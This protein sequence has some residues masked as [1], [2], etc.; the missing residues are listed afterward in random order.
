M[1]QSENKEVLVPGTKTQSGLVLV[2]LTSGDLPDLSTADVFPFDLAADY[3]TP[4][5]KGES[6]R[7][8]FDK[9]APQKVLDQ[10]T[11]EVIELECA[12]F[13]EVVNGEAK[14]ISNGSKRLVG[15]LEANNIQRGAP[16]LITYL[17]K[18]KN[19]SNGFQSDSW[20]IKMLRLSI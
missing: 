9:I 3:W 1:S 20:S 7:V 11:G 2:D 6:K 10:Q 5:N 19:K 12:S 16:L 14:S 13:I 15:A 4:E 18:K 8:M 17:G